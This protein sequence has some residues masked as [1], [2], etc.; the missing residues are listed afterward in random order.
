MSTPRPKFCDLDTVSKEINIAYNRNFSY[1]VTKKKRRSK[2]F[3]LTKFT[4][5][6][7]FIKFSVHLAPIFMCQCSSNNMS[8]CCHVLKILVEYF[9]L[10]SELI[11]YLYIPE[12]RSALTELLESDNVN[13]NY[14]EILTKE[15]Y[16]YF[17]DECGICCELL[18]H[19]KYKLR[20]FKCDTCTRYVHSMCMEQW[21]KQ[22]SQPLNQT[23]QLVQKGC[24]Y[25]REKI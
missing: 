25:C 4:V 6:D 23:K 12:L 7:G 17:F 13:N 16:E 3:D 14:Y 9:G 18:S 10:T 21:Y 20:L 24:I 2:N 5:Q 1:S 8:Y 15:L 22:K 11:A 19:K